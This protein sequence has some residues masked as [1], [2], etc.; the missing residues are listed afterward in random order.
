MKLKTHQSP[1][2]H[3][4]RTYQLLTLSLANIYARQ[5]A[6]ASLIFAD[7]CGFLTL[8]GLFTYLAFQK[9]TLI[10]LPTQNNCNKTLDEIWELGIGLDVVLCHHSAQ[11]RPKTI[12]TLRKRLKNKRPVTV[13]VDESRYENLA[14]CERFRN[15]DNK[16]VLRVKE[17][18]NLLVLEGSSLV[19]QHLAKSCLDLRFRED[20]PY[21]S[22]HHLSTYMTWKNKFT[23]D[24]QLIH[25]DAQ[26]WEQ[27]FENQQELG[28]DYTS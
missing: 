1:V 14:F 12:R 21:E 9:D 13:E 28:Q 18:G 27:W 11:M 10:Y 22:H 4:G 25:F 15:R 20:H 19:F 24:S 23:N 8:A 2:T 6:T 26:A 7:G 5:F 3:N 16:D 17:D